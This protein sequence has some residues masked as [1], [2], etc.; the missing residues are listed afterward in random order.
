MT[1]KQVLRLRE[2]T[3]QQFAK[4]APHTTPAAICK[5]RMMPIRGDFQSDS[6]VAKERLALNNN[7]I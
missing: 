7:Y 4:P 5:C 2:V 1:Q 6:C 3:S